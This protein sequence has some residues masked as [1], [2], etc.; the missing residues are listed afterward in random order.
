MS[1]LRELIKK[2]ATIHINDLIKLINPKLWGWANYYRHCVAKQVFGYVG[3]KLFYLL[4]HWAVRCHPTKSKT[5]LLNTSSTEKASGNFTIGRR[6]WIWI[7]N[8][9][10]SK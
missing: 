1:N 6:S 5:W 3:H 4:W 10:Y 7:A 9:I 8:L 2:H